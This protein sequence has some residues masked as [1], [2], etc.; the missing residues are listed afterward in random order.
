MK[1]LERCRLGQ[2]GSA[3]IDTV[4][5]EQPAVETF[6]CVLGVQSGVMPWGGVWGGYHCEHRQAFLPKAYKE[7]RTQRRGRERHPGPPHLACIN[8]SHVCGH[9]WAE[10]DPQLDLMEDT[11]NMGHNIAT[12]KFQPPNSAP[13]STIYHLV[14]II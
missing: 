8:G 2:A 3:G 11:V 12:A 4:C 10:M 14:L 6:S 1:W 13:N 9:S 7:P 5:R